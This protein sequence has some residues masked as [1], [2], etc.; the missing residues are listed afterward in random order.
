MTPLCPACAAGPAQV[1][2]HARLKATSL[3]E[4]G[5]AFTCAD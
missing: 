1:E 2:G 5:M 4:S 3:G